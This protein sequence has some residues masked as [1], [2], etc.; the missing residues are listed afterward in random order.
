MKQLLRRFTTRAELRRKVLHRR[1]RLSG[2][3]LPSFGRRLAPFSRDYGFD[4]GTPVDRH[5]I[6]AF[7]SRYATF[8]GYGTG[9][10][11]GVTLEV[12]GDEYARAYGGSI[13]RLDVLHATA[14]NPQATIV[15]DLATG[16]GLRPGVYDCVICTQTLQ[17]IYDVRAAVATLHDILKPGGVVL[18]TV[19]GIAGAVVPDRHLWGDFW[20]FTR[21]S[22]RRLFEASFP[23]E[24][25]EVE[26]FGN[27]LTATAYLHGLSAEELSAG[28]RDSHDPRYE[29]LLAV[30][31]RR[32]AE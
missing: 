29:L 27:L 15:G 12:G 8:A 30:R 13:E 18:V 28:Q 24:N 25:V 32:A 4:R 19:P 3:R 17:S 1:A 6:Q 2:Y 31:A 5:Y 11:R 14:D 20:R 23:A 16:D 7:L 21:G 10:V 26:G 22:L 9:D